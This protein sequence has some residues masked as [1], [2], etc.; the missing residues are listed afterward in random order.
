MVPCGHGAKALCKDAGVIRL[1]KAKKNSDPPSAAK[2]R[3]DLGDDDSLPVIVPRSDKVLVPTS[4]ARIR[5]LREHL[6]V[7]LH[8]MKDSKCCASPLRPE[9]EGFAARVAQTACSLCRGWCCRNGGDVGFLDDRTMTR[10][11]VARPDMD[12]RAVRRLYIDRVPEAVYKDLC[13]FHGKRGCT[14][15]RSLR[16]DVCNSYFCGGLGA[17]M[18]TRAAVP[19]RVIAG[20]NEKMRT[21][22]VLVPET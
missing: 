1:V 18:K 2:R 16:A 5:R 19:T 20:E 15:D 14:L 22:P 8:T 9:P 3:R 11:R 21:S 13:I 4:A 6:R 7:A 17:Y 12:A 10:V